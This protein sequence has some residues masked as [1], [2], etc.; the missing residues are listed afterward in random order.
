MIPLIFIILILVSCS[1]WREHGI[2]FHEGK[3]IKLVIFPV[4]CTVDIKNL[5]SIQTIQKNKIPIE[6]EKEKIQIL[7]SETIQEMTSS[8][9]KNLKDSNIFEVAQE[10]NVLNL[11]QKFGFS[12]SIR[13]ISKDQIMA[14]GNHFNAD[15]ILF[16]Q[17]SGYGKIKKKWQLYLIGSGMVEALVQG[18]AMYKISKNRWAGIALGVEEIAQELLT[19]VGGIALFNKFFT[20][21]ILE[22]KLYST[23]DGLPF[24]SKTIIS[25]GKKKDF[26]NLPKDEQKLKENRLQIVREKA[27]KELIKDME[28]KAKS[29]SLNVKAKF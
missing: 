13:N 4:E 29:Q 10:D 27:I 23:F 5:K 25:L 22:A 28:K 15:A 18:V 6:S 16:V 14:I 21:V 9:R 24:W 3:K 19:W 7:I 26:K 17:M 20:P 1:T 12:N 2:Y 8:L 11:L